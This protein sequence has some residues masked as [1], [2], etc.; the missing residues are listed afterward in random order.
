[1]SKMMKAS[2]NNGF[3]L[4]E[5]LIVAL[6]MGILSSIALPMYQ[7]Y[8]LRAKLTE[9]ITSL[10]NVRGKIEQYF[11]DNNTY[12]GACSSTAILSVFT[13]LKYFT[14]T[15]SNLTDSTYT[16][17]ATGSGFQYN[18]DQSNLRTTTQV[19]D[20]WSTSATCWTTN[21]SGKCQ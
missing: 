19:P 16:I 3:T 15:C 17:T 18:L 4:I 1:M 10:A 6:I 2:K 7:E 9:G 21:K 13:D 5:V 14:I 20:G 8:L 12:V 11:Q